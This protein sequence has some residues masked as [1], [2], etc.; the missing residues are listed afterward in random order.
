METICFSETL[1]SIDDL[2]R[3]LNPEVQHHHLRDYWFTDSAGWEVNL[4]NLDWDVLPL[5]FFVITTMFC[6]TDSLS[7]SYRSVENVDYFRHTQM[8]LTQWPPR[9]HCFHLVRQWATHAESFSLIPAIC[10]LSRSQVSRLSIK[11]SATKRNFMEC[12][13]SPCG[14]IE[15]CFIKKDF[16]VLRNN[17]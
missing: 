17:L 10:M 9:Q 8:P 7:V 16:I 6:T 2:T 15:T 11:C 4:V 12:A 3:R 1:S 14:K 5:R 13:L